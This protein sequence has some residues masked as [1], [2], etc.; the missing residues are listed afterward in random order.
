MREKQYGEKII[1]TCTQCK[2]EGNT[3]PP[4]EAGGKRQKE[5]HEC[6]VKGMLSLI[7]HQSS[8]RRR[9]STARLRGTL[10]RGKALPVERKEKLRKSNRKTMPR[11][12]D[13]R[14]REVEIQ[15]VLA[16]FL[17][18]HSPIFTRVP[19]YRF[20]AI[21]LKLFQLPFSSY[22]LLRFVYA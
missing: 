17:H 20:S 16:A 19:L 7:S 18:F 4:E 11:R 13:K 21:F 12:I 5:N 1:Y 3:C 2:R 15:R 22:L 9:V 10:E 8:L 6:L 14:R